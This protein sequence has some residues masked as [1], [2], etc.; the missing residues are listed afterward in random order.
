[1]FRQKVNCRLDIGACLL[2]GPSQ[3][4]ILSADC[5]SGSETAPVCIEGCVLLSWWKHDWTTWNETCM[6]GGTII[7][8]NPSVWISLV[9]Y[10][11]FVSGYGIFMSPR[12]A[13]SGS[14]SSC[15]GSKINSLN[16]KI[17][18]LPTLMST[19]YYLWY[20]PDSRYGRFILLFLD[21]WEIFVHNG[22]KRLLFVGK[23]S[24]TNWIY[25]D[26]LIQ[27]I[28]FRR[29]SVLASSSLTCHL[30]S[31]LRN[32]DLENFS[33]MQFVSEVEMVVLM[34]QYQHVT[35]WKYK[36]ACFLTL[37]FYFHVE[38]TKRRL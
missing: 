1:M 25:L 32:V 5:V 14:L 8:A 15:T 24:T 29:T 23:N 13:Q 38:R 27:S 31:K 17:A 11:L 6:R 30:F 18:Q 33:L 3:E 9:S 26:I 22:N 19:Q 35:T 12:C 4:I 28:I 2:T 21:K 37:D 20:L 16:S 10:W 7:T 36:D 34:I